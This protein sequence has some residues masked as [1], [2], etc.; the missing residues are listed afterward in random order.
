M[1][2][3]LSVAKLVVFLFLM[4]CVKHQQPS[5]S[6]VFS[7]D[8]NTWR[9]H[10]KAVP[11][12]VRLNGFEPSIGEVSADNTIVVFSNVQCAT[13]KNEIPRIKKIVEQSNGHFR[14]LF[15]HFPLN[16]RC[17][18]GLKETLRPRDCHIAQQLACAGQQ[19]QFWSFLELSLTQR[20]R[21]QRQIN[22]SLKGLKMSVPAFFECISEPAE[23]QNVI[24]DAR[25]GQQAGVM[26][27]PT[28]FVF[29]N[30]TQRWWRAKNGEQSI[31]QLHQWRKAGMLRFP[32]L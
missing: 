19:G 30:A 18:P 9:A 10:F 11:N 21:T 8:I 28:I 16:R 13:C 14:L 15:K 31:R 32:S 25:S 22:K 23:R 20:L 29:D 2:H 12:G 6:S 5:A 7:P 1:K 27:L 4:A 26:M 3:M 17:N 24:D